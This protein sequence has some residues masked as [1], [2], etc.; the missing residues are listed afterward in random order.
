LDSSNFSSRIFVII[1]T[2]YYRTRGRGGCGWKRGQ[3]KKDG[4][5][6]ERNVEDVCKDEE[7]QE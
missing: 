2:G 6:E 4:G 3:R 7:Y 5:K 1:L